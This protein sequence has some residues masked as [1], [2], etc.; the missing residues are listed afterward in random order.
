MIFHIIKK[1]F[2]AFLFICLATCVSEV[3]AATHWQT[4]APGIDYTNIVN[5]QDPT[6]GFLHCFKINL[7]KNNL[8][9]A[10]AKDDIFPGETVKW[11]A[12]RNRALLAVNGGFF[13]SA[14]APIGLRI[15]NFNQRSSLQPTSWWPIFYIKNNIPS[16]IDEK[17]YKKDTN[18]FF[19]V[20][21]GPR[22]LRNGVIP[23]LKAGKAERTALG[24]TADNEVI[25]VATEH[26]ALSTEQLAHI[27]KEQLACAEAMNLDG[28]SS[29]QLY[30]HI[31]D[32]QLDIGSIALITDIVYVTP[33]T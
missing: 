6:F 20:Q 12:K 9:L 3:S 32:F 11:L 25:I 7:K 19:A 23:P 15:Q 5:N 8:Q 31:N 2:K 18:I 14:W 17:N 27:F 16:I 1:T 21:G 28:G 26:W 13:T 10:L 22:L 33:K 30:A 24:I 4:L 29:T